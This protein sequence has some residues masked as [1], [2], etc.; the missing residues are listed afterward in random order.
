[1]GETL[2]FPTQ[3]WAQSVRCACPLARPRGQAG[4][5]SRHGG[6]PGRAPPRLPFWRLRDWSTRARRAGPAGWSK[7]GN[8]RGRRKQEQA[9]P[10]KLPRLSAVRA[11]DESKRP[12]GKAKLR[13]GAATGRASRSYRTGR[14]PRPL[15]P[16]LGSPRLGPGTARPAALPG[17][18]CSRGGNSGR[19]RPFKARARYAACV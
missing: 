16:D 12:A 10:A 18:D 8:G 13:P 5:C 9:E 7:G 14:R 19:R 2:L 11:D 17:T 4:H 1:M 15:L 6:G 3:N